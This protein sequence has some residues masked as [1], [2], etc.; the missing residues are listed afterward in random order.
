MWVQNR[1]SKGKALCLD[2]CVDGV[3][4]VMPVFECAWVKEKSYE[5]E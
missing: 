5:R 4:F 1:I 3:L 2:V